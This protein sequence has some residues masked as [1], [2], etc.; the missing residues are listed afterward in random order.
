MF[1]NLSTRF[2]SCLTYLF[3][4]IYLLYSVYTT[5]L[6]SLVTR[7]AKFDSWIWKCEGSI[8]KMFISS[9]KH[10]FILTFSTKKHVFCRSKSINSGFKPQ[11]TS[12]PSYN[13]KFRNIISALLHLLLYSTISI[14]NPLSSQIDF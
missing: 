6:Y 14:I 12:I 10:H 3:I 2:F 11:M 1:L 9:R 5:V 13:T 7:G 8:L 4:F